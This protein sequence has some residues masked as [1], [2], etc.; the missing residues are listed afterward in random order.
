LDPWLRFCPIVDEFNANR[1]NTLHNDG[2][3][4]VDESTSAYQPRL[5]K[6]GGMPNIVSFIKRKPKPLGIEFKTMCDTE[7]GVMKYMEIQEGKDAMRTK[8]FTDELGVTAGY[9]ARMAS[10]CATYA[11]MSGDSWFGSVKVYV[12]C[13]YACRML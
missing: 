6:F 3:I 2:G 4:I 7:T 5:D 1:A 9:V 11:T 13:C 12:F 10:A 8:P